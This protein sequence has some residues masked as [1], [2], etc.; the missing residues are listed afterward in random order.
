M[1]CLSFWTLRSQLDGPLYWC[2]IAP[3][4]MDL[5]YVTR[6]KPAADR[7]SHQRKEDAEED[8]A[9]RRRGVGIARNVLCCCAAKDDVHHPDHENQAA[10]SNRKTPHRNPVQGSHRLI[11][12]AIEPAGKHAADKQRHRPGENYPDGG[13]GR[14]RIIGVEPMESDGE[15]ANVN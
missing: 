6:A 7:R 4:M 11:C 1:H 3:H 9:H 2:V 12:L 8:Y 15:S 13:A 5:V 14:S 10:R